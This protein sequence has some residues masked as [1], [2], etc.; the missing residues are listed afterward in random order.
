MGRRILPDLGRC[1]VSLHS[2]LHLVINWCSEDVL[3]KYWKS[4]ITTIQVFLLK[5]WSLLHLSSYCV[6]IFGSYDMPRGTAGRNPPLQ[7]T[8]FT[9]VLKGWATKSLYRMTQ[10]PRPKTARADPGERQ[11][12]E[13]SPGPLSAS[14]SSWVRSGAAGPWITSWKRVVESE[15]GATMWA[16]HF[17][18]EKE[19]VHS[20]WYIMA[21][22]WQRISILHLSFSTYSSE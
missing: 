2:W 10:S 8:D 19:E 1:A 6:R 5:L 13:L 21:V 22:L 4:T 18:F 14:A 17:S 11:Q 16:P 9:S 15:D 3:D 12:S 7:M 20:L